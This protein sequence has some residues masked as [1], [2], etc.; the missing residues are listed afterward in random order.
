MI[1]LLFVPLAGAAVLAVLAPLAGRSAPVD[2]VDT[3]RAF[4]REQIAEIERERAEG[5]LDAKDAEAART[6]A[7]RRLL[8]AADAQE[9]GSRPPSARRARVVA[10]LATALLAP[11]AAVLLY[12]RVGS[13]ELPDQPLADRL[14][15]AAAAGPHGDL[16]GAVAMIEAHLAQHPEDGRGFEVV[17]P[18]YLRNGRFEEAIRAYEAAL[19]LL[20]ATPARHAT[21]G[22]AI[23]IAAQG[24]VTQEARRH[25]E[26][27]LA[28]DPADPMSRY[29]L[30]LAA[31]QD[32]DADRALALW[33]KLLEDA[34]ANAGYRA[35]VQ[36]QIDKLHG[37]GT[38][39]AVPALP[40]NDQQAFIRAMVERL[41]GRLAQKG[42]DVE[43]WLKLLRAYAVL[44]E[45]QKA[46]IALLDARKAL[47]GK[48]EE[49]SR[50]NA[51]AAELGIE[52]KTEE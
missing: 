46:R 9:V 28:L 39:R 4:Y 13:P 43:G 25:F 7:A 50:V 11:L 45:P 33:S 48:P 49:A 29:Y 41:A 20:G 32:G 6:E 14:A 52:G 30:A 23:A 40:E 31:A 42:D 22:E 47:A 18:Y 17:A 5:R 19:R 2:R 36:N 15:A 3:D 16:S 37:A 24:A 12:L 1:W 27:A 38:G 35:L 51:L 26:A 8:R 21:L 34:P 44:S 10:A